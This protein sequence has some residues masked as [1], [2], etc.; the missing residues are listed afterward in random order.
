M[1]REEVAK[2]AFRSFERFGRWRRTVGTI[3]RLVTRWRL[4][5]T[6]PMRRL[7]S[8]VLVLLAACDDGGSTEPPL[9]AGPPFDGG[10]MFDA[11]AG[12]GG[13]VAALVLSDGESEWRLD[14]TAVSAPSS[15]AS[16][17]GHNAFWFAW[18][19]FNPGTELFGGGAVRDATLES[20]DDCGVPCEEIIPGCPGRDC[21]PPL[22]SPDMVTGTPDY[23]ADTDMVL[24]VV[25]SEG[26][27]AYPHNILWW[28][29]VINEEVGDEAF[30][31]TFCPLT[32]SGLRYDRR[33]FVEGET[34][35]LGVSGL[36]Y[37]SN[38]ILWDRETETL[39]SQ[40]GL[41]GIQGAN[42]GEASPVEPIFEMTWA[43]WQALHPDTLVV[44]ESTGHS[45]DYRRYPYTRGGDYRTND[46]DTFRQ[47]NP[48]P[49]AQF[50]NK[51][52][53]FGIT[54]GTERRAYVWE[55][56]RAEAGGP[57]GVIN[58]R[59]GD[60]PIA[61]VFDLDASYV[62]AFER[63]EAELSLVPAAE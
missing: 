36:L 3:A 26:P 18:S 59:I 21:I 1:G 52:M 53:V 22:D 38:L 62:H 50:A 28:H 49:D 41:D 25:T 29:E 11:G 6:T 47:T 24:G 43:A 20:T 54:R 32:G 40:M 12:A 56:L 16:V 57:R 19:I 58:D 55:L 34:V 42:L 15:L 60:T 23:L 10:A 48:L 51:D 63:G 44:S 39:W 61:V 5:T 8:M 13:N 4:R 30:T 35:R 7:F 46:A 45:R 31:V 27:R 37:N 17:P 33:G 14:G 2:G 9:D